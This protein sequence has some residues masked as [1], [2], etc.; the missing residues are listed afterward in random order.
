V[1]DATL[2]ARAV[3]LGVEVRYEDSEGRWHDA[4]A[5][6]LAVVVDV[7]EADA[8]SGGRPVVEPVEVVTNAAVLGTAAT[9]AVRGAIRDAMLELEGDTSVD[10]TWD[11]RD[12]VHH[13]VLPD[14]IPVGCHRLSVRTS[15]G[16]SACTVVVA[17]PLMPRSAALAGRSALFVPAY[18]LWDD[19]A[20]LPSYRLLGRLAEVLPSHGT[21]V[22][23]TLPLHA[24]F[25]D[26]P[27]D[28]SPYA[29]V[30]RLHWNELYIDDADLPAAPVPP[31]GRYLDW[32]T[33]AERRRAQLVRAADELDDRAA[34]RLEAFV[35]ERP[36][37]DAFARFLTTRNHGAADPRV[38]TSHVLAQH[39]AERELAEITRAGGATLAFDLPI[40]CH[41]EGFERWAA[42]EL[43]AEAMSIGAPPDTFFREGQSWGLP[44]QL[45]AA[46]RRSGH[47]LWRDLLSRT[48]EH[49][50]LLRIDHVMA[51][52]RLWWIPDGFGPH[53][54]VYVRYPREELLAVIAA[55]AVTTD[56]TI[57]GEDL[58]TVPD[59]V[60]EALER[61]GVLGMYEEMFHTAESPLPRIPPRTVAGVRT[62]DMEAFATFALMTDL[63]GYRRRLRR[64]LGRPAGPTTE[65]LHEAVLERLARSDAWLVA[66]DLDDLLG[67]TEPH[68]RPGRVLE[69]T[70]RRRLDQ[71]LSATLH[72]PRVHRGLRILADRRRG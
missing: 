54:G 20:P 22:L 49:A 46:G 18:A 58:G 48:G 3:E 25:L 28:P 29:P 61:W 47:R 65:A 35:A 52:H 69:T 21:D 24:A 56:T 71:P 8:R 53:Q 1:D 34:A 39:L 44:P 15:D 19:D 26:D 11:R 70:W 31:Q 6:A 62:H 30:S 42:P 68:N 32:A 13:V 60:V 36:D 23:T 64:S 27:F 14:A 2:R 10:V 57:V 33:L 40:G 16:D 4:H 38:V 9:I 66:C 41:P 7:L 12:G 50:S 51:V 5:E 72:D 17:P 37:V 55:M 59:E 43:F 45:P 63:G 67:E